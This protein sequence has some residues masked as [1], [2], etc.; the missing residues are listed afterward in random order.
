VRVSLRR[1]TIEPL[2]TRESWICSTISRVRVLELSSLKLTKNRQVENH[3]GAAMCKSFDKESQGKGRKVKALRSAIRLWVTGEL[4]R[5]G[6][7]GIQSGLPR[8]RSNEGS[9]I[10]TPGANIRRMNIT[11]SG[12]RQSVGQPRSGPRSFRNAIMRASTACSSSS[13][14]TTTGSASACTWQSP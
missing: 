6:R 4:A 14:R 5:A 1:E 13:A 7:S 11:C 12:G 8:V 2:C 9:K 10:P 3:R